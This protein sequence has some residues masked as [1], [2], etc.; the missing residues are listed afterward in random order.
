MAKDAI[1]E[2]PDV[3]IEGI[4]SILKEEKQYFGGHY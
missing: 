4:Q 2:G 1:K 3:K